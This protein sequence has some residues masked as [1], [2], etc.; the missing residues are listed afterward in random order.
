MLHV[1][2]HLIT[3]LIILMLVFEWWEKC[4]ISMST[5]RESAF[6]CIKCDVTRNCSILINNSFPFI[7]GICWPYYRYA[8]F[9]LTVKHITTQKSPFNGGLSKRRRWWM[10]MK[11]DKKMM[12]WC[13]GSH[14]I[15]IHWV[16]YDMLNH[17]AFYMD[18]FPMHQD[19][20][21]ER[22]SVCTLKTKQRQRKQCRVWGCTR[23]V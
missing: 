8:Q 1:A 18:R 10:V 6:L 9:S 11:I 19:K 15:L 14:D 16:I 23:L 17:L 12:C 13:T 2:E 21:K 7:F 20:K 22:M 5:P 4:W 3:K